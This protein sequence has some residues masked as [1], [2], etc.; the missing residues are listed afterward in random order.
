MCNTHYARSWR[1]SPLDA[2]I[3][4]WKYGETEC[5]VENCA[6]PAKSRGMCD[7]HYQRVY[8]GFGGEIDAP[9]QHRAPGEWSAWK[10]NKD[11]YRYRYRDL[12]GKREQQL[13][14]RV[15]MEQ[16][17]GRTLVKGENVH[18][19][20]GD[21]ADNRRKN[22]ELWN[23]SQPPGQRW[24]DKLEWAREIIALYS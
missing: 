17:L 14:H 12:N 4:V 15:L 7:S 2:P 22:L 5:S 6:R 21:R 24:Q 23:T 10:I 9:F 1:G 13:E 11:G 3:Q 16:W 8:Q 18:H 20:N 19:V